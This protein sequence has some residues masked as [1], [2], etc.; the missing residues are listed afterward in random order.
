MVGSAQICGG[1]RVERLPPACY[2]GGLQA[3]QLP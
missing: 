3:A 1:G 2:I